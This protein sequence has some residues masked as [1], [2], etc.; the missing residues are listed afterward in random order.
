MT[1]GLAFFKTWLTLFPFTSKDYVAFI[2]KRVKQL[3]K[4]FLLDCW[5]LG[6][7]GNTIC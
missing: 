3:I 6:G 7:Q 5:T 4:N 2:F 1:M